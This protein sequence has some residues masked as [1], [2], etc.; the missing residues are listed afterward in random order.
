VA[1]AADGQVLASGSWDNTVKLWDARTGQELR[2]L[3]GHMDRVTSVAFAADGEVLASADYD[4]TV[5]VWDARTGAELRSLRWHTF[6]VTSLAFAAD[7]HVLA[8]ASFDRTLKLWDTRSGQELRTLC[9]HTTVV[10]SVAFAADGKTLWSR[11]RNGVT[12]AWDLATGERIKEG[13]APPAFAGGRGTW[14]PDGEVFASGQANGLILLA[15]RLPSAQEQRFRAWITSPDLHL[16][17]DEAEKADKAKLPFALAFRLGRYL[18][19]QHH[20]A[21]AATQRASVAAWLAT[22]PE[23]LNLLGGLPVH[24]KTPFSAPTFPDGIACAGILYKDSN[25]DPRRL[26]IGTSR[27]LDGDPTSWLNHAFHGGALYRNGELEKALL[28]LNKAV[29]LHG[30]PSVLGNNL[31]GLINL[32]LGKKEKATAAFAVARPTKDAPW[33]DV[34]LQRLLQ[35]EIDAALA[36]AEP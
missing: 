9:G 2:T 27:A 4:N 3:R 20:Y 6:W 26:V 13:P 25:I 35:P 12:L 11:D 19:G 1:F 36:K 32:A 15:P 14:S 10:D 21:G 18:A 30:K 24:V 23:R 34:M 17:R 28:A 22:G 31:L 33:E 16:H 7:G 29:A 5:K 8:S